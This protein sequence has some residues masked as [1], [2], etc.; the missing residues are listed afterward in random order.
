[1]GK[2]TPLHTAAA[3]GEREEVERLLDS[4]LY[5]V[6]E[7]SDEMFLEGVCVRKIE[8]ERER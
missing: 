5:D 6:N 1:M 3:I 8:R 4:G 7:G 2:K